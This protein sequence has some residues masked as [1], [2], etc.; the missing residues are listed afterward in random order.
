M[1]S[2]GIEQV[3]IAA[4]IGISAPTLRKW[5]KRE[6]ASAAHEANAQVIAALFKNATVGKNVIAQIWWTKTRLGWKEVQTVEN[7]GK[8]GRPIE[9]IVT[10]RWADPPAD[11]G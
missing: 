9:Q 6:I 2:G 3:H 5:Y 7:V 8:D 10:Y 1:I 4:A 11:K